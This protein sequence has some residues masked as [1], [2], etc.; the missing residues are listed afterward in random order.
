MLVE[1]E[2]ELVAGRG[3][4][5]HGRIVGHGVDE[6]STRPSSARVVLGMKPVLLGKVGP[7]SRPS[8]PRRG[9]LS[10][11][12]RR[13]LGTIGGTLLSAALLSVS[14][15]A[16]AEWA[17]HATEE[18]VAKSAL[19]GVFTAE[20]VDPHAYDRATKQARTRLVFRVNTLLEGEWESEMVEFFVP[21]GVHPDGSEEVWTDLPEFNQGERYLL[22]IRD[23]KWR[24]TPIVA[25]NQGAYRIAK[26]GVRE[27]LVNNDGF[28]VSHLS[29]QGFRLE[30]RRVAMSERSLRRIR[31]GRMD[32]TAVAE[33]K[34]DSIAREDAEQELV[35]SEL[36]RQIKGYQTRA[37]QGRAG[38]A[39]KRVVHRHATPIAIGQGRSTP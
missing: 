33:L 6:R 4:R 29:E 15:G 14:R 1:P 5:V 25:G 26:V 27:V 39:R 38:L 12:R 31:S 32:A 36:R 8:S 19:V 3:R 30:P 13:I 35:L 17:P 20:V 22:F 7:G 10:L 34:F 23:G 11:G 21:G 24:T 18:L 2:H 28:V 16:S 37:L 9:V